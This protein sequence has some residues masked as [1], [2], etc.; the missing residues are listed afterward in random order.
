MSLRDQA[1]KATQ[2]LLKSFDD[3]E[4]KDMNLHQLL[5][6]Q[7]EKGLIEA[8]LIRCH[9]NQLWA[10]NILGVARNTLRKK[11]DLLGIKAKKP[12]K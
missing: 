8:V 9:F 5:L 2:T 10:A 6:E 4:L 11:M 7:V 12:T 3:H 1:F